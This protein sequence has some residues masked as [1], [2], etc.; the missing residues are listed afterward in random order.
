[1]RKCCGREIRSDGA[2]TT[3]TTTGARSLYGQCAGVLA[4]VRFRLNLTATVANITRDVLRA[5]TAESRVL[6]CI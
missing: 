6:C 2:T 1:M 4:R 3:T 5:A